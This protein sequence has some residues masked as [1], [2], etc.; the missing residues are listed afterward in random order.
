MTA[1]TT[2]VSMTCA[3]CYRPMLGPSVTHSGGLYYHPECSPG[4]RPT[5]TAPPEKIDYDRIRQIVREE[6]SKAKT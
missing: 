2:Y 1:E 3:H 4:M 6:I 5:F